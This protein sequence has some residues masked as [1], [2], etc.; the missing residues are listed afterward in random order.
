[1]VDEA[2]RIATRAQRHAGATPGAGQAAAPDDGGGQESVAVSPRPPVR[3]RFVHAWTSRKRR[4]PKRRTPRFDAIP[5]TT[6][7]RIRALVEGTTQTYLAIAA[8]VGV[9]AATVSRYAVTG[10]WVRPCGAAASMRRAHDVRRSRTGGGTMSAATGASWP[11]QPVEPPVGDQRSLAWSSLWT[12]AARQA[13]AL[14][15]WSGPA[16]PRMISSLAS[17][18][19]TL[20]HLDKHAA[21]EPAPAGDE[22]PPRSLEELRQ[23]L[24]RK[25]ERLVADEE[26]ERA[27]SFFAAEEEREALWRAE[28]EGWFADGDGI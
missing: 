17:V 18:T 27:F 15:E 14:Q 19:R 23:L 21:P 22:P 6:V 2:R 5:S 26:K 24:S 1:M 10:G 28:F 25:L 3:K 7:E 8:E 12:A 4:S 13:M 20:A 11:S 9:S 16:D